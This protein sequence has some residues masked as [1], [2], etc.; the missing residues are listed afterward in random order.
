HIPSRSSCTSSTTRRR[1][2]R[3]ACP[4]RPPLDKN[5]RASTALKNDGGLVAVPSMPHGPSSATLSESFLSRKT[6]LPVR[7]NL[8]RPWVIRRRRKVNKEVGTTHC[9]P[10]P[11]AV[12]APK[13][14]CRSTRP[15]AHS[16][17]GRNQ[18][19]P[20]LKTTIAV[21]SRMICWHPQLSLS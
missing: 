4:I 7:R 3:R 19:G 13:E 1:L 17:G 15:L 21:S 12:L 9:A 11:A 14:D 2:R 16:A 8:I 18:A 20:T 6:S 5:F 10:C